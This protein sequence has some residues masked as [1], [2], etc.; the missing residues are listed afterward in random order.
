MR[1]RMKPSTTLPPLLVK[2]LD[3]LMA[4]IL[5][6]SITPSDAIEK[7]QELA[8][9]HGVHAVY[10]EGY[11]WGRL[12]V[13]ARSGAYPAPSTKRLREHSPNQMPGKVR[14]KHLKD[15]PVHL[16]VLCTWGS[17]LPSDG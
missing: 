7:G 12:V 3:K 15:K 4:D 13:L 9:G 6:L 11:I 10:V 14:H 1:K 5:E 17:A 16:R 8:A 2:A